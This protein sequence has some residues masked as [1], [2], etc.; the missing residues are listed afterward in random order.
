MTKRTAL[1]IAHVCPFPKNKGNGARLLCVLD[2]LR[3]KGFR[4]VFVLQPLDV[5]H[6]ESVGE[7]NRVVDELIVVPRHDFVGRLVDAL[8]LPIRLA[9]RLRSMAR[10]ASASADD[11]LAD[12]CWP[13]TMRAVA[14]A[15]RRWPPDLVVSEYAFFSPCF[16]RV[17]PAAVKVIDTIEVFSRDP[18]QFSKAGVQPN[19]VVSRESESACLQRADLVLG[20]QRDDAEFLKALVPT[21]PVITLGH[22]YSQARPRAAYPRRG[23]VLYVGSSNEYNRHGLESFAA[24]AWPKIRRASPEAE[25]HIV[26][27]ARVSGLGARDGVR[28]LGRVDEA[29]LAECYQTAHVV[30]NPQLTGTGLKI[31]CVEALS[32]GCPLVANAAGADGL[33]DGAGT[34]FLVADSWDRFAD[35]VVTLLQNDEARLALEAEAR[36]FAAERFSSS[37]VFGD[38]EKFIDARLGDIR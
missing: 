23:V 13:S 11:E 27:E 20:I 21:K 28:L 25:L 37:A 34:A 14:R 9:R 12:R 31:K 33:R 22:V 38:F 6:P 16:D 5:E 32:A 4:L 2:W 24:H 15:A 8:S 30:I 26:G 3:A 29:R 36:R 19:L 7:L 17:P 35:H 18:E 10:P 1:V